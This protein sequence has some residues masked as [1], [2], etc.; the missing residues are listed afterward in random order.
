MLLRLIVIFSIAL[1]RYNL[2]S[3]VCTVCIVT[4]SLVLRVCPN[5]LF[6]FLLLGDSNSY[7]LIEVLLFIIDNLLPELVAVFGT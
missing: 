6:D 3:A 2:S 1:N 4:R 5:E 7:V